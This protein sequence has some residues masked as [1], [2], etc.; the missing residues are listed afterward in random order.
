[1][2]SVND[3]LNVIYHRPFLVRQVVEVRL[4]ALV[5]H[6][7]VTVLVTRLYGPDIPARTWNIISQIKYKIIY[8]KR[9]FSS[10]AESRRDIPGEISNQLHGLHFYTA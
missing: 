2:K 10:F 7:F 1:M 3:C 4:S 6:I 8:E 5:L 9:N